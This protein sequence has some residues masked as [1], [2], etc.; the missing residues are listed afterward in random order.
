ML[1]RVALIIGVGLIVLLVA[2][3]VAGQVP[4]TPDVVHAQAHADSIFVLHANA[5]RNCCSTMTL[6]LVTGSFVADF[7]EGEAE[8][9]C[10]CECC[11]D[12]HYDARGFAAG[13]WL[14]RVWNEAG[15]ELFGQA[16]VDVS[17]AGSNAALGGMDRGDCVSVAV[18]PSTWSAVRRTYH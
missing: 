6:R 1:L 17:G 12:L 7:Y 10:R 9:F 8:P 13:H 4:C 14:V 16:E 3:T 18:Q 11:F 2:P 5:Q 15:T